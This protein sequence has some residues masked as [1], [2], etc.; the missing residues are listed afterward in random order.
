MLSIPR[1]H[2]FAN[3]ILYSPEDGSYAGFDR[4]EFTSR[5]HGKPAA[6]THIRQ[7]H[8]HK[9]VV[10]IGDGATD[11]EARVPGC[12]DLFVCYGGVVLRPK[13]AEGADWVVTSFDPLIKA[14]Q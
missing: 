5:S 8:G 14:L 13:V 3:V 6:I 7:S 10:M 11:L 1:E 12:A 4:N 2:V 9:R